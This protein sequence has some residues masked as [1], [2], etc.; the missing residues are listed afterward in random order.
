Q[1]LLMPLIL[2]ASPAQKSQESQWH[3]NL[4]AMSFDI[5]EFGPNAYN[6]RGIP[7]FMELSEAEQFLNHFIE[8]AGELKGDFDEAKSEKIAMQACKMA[9]RANDMLSFEGAEA[10]IKQLSLCENPYSCPHGRPTFVKI[11]KGEI[12]KL[13]K[14]I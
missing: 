1:P 8:S 2:E 14:R 12:E 7:I 13:F 6:I 3:D 5:E 11:T 9:V 4:R 10:L